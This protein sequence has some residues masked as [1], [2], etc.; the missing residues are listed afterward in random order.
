MGI[1]KI[2]ELAEDLVHVDPASTFFSVATLYHASGN[3]EK[4]EEFYLKSLKE[5][6]NFFLAEYKLARA[7]IEGRK[8]DEAKKVL[9]SIMKTQPDFIEASILYG[10]VLM[11]LEDYQ[12]A[13]ETYKNLLER[14]EIKEYARIAYLYHNLGLSLYR[15]GDME[16]AIQFFL[17]SLDS[18][19]VST[20]VLFS[21]ILVNLALT[22]LK[23]GMAEKAIEK[24]KWGIEKD[25]TDPEFHA[26]LGGVYLEENNPKYAREY[27]EKALEI[28][29]YNALALE[30]LE[31]LETGRDSRE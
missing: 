3:L 1:R 14:E 24:L 26:V 25:S 30:K 7:Y 2:E 22:Y 15:N 27:L 13:I 19:N 16:E 20:N 17:K 21:G 9:E 29:P 18:V 12:N 5:K 8:Y 6:E 28:D 10:D 23:A 31:E 11:D 4:A